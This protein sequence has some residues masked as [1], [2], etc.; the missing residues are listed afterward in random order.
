M[1]SSEH[2][3]GVL[4]MIGATLCW[5]T[6]G[7]LVRNMSLT[8]GWEITF[9]RSL[10]MTV[11][12]MGVL[13]VQY[14]RTTI[15]RIRAVGRSGVMVGALWALMYVSFILAIGR[16]TIA[17]VLVLSSISP[18]AAALMGGLFL[19]ERVPGRTLLAMLAAFAGVVLMFVD[20]IGS[21]G[22]TGNLIA[23]AIPLAFACNVVLLR[24]MHVSVDMIPTLV[25]SG[26][27][28]MALTLPLALPID[29]STQDIGLLAIMGVVQL[30]IGLLLM[31]AA[32]PRLKAAE[33]G[34]L[35]VT[36]TI[37]GTFLT[38]LVIGEKPGE[39]ALIGGLIVIAALVINEA[40]GLRKK[41][42]SP[43]EE[44]AVQTGS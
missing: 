20:S 13:L 8:D 21:G 24:K 35:S 5:S 2:R 32:T 6:A 29:A 22:L 44:R 3:K 9:W 36:E 39:L 11:F 38:W 4:L 40:V 27:I 7:V 41:S 10:F 43:G 14:G 18:F 12:V 26:I 30:A 15:A 28:S 16:T 17:N 34:L 1:T 37:F 19:H 42:A 23:L 25:I 33:I 31:L